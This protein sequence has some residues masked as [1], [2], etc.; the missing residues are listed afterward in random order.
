MNNSG[1]EYIADKDSALLQYLYEILA[2]QSRTSIKAY[3]THA[4][5]TVNGQ[6]TTAFDHPVRKGDRISILEKGMIMKKRGGEKK[7]PE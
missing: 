2:G 1:R 4:R 6:S 5:I 7:R 3:L